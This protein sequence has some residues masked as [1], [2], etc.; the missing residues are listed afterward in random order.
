MTGIEIVQL[1]SPQ[2]T[3][4]TQEEVMKTEK[5]VECDHFVQQ[6]AGMQTSQKM[7][8]S[9]NN[10]DKYK[11]SQSSCL[12]MAELTKAINARLAAVVLAFKGLIAFSH[13]WLR[14]CLEAQFS[15]SNFSSFYNRRIN[16]V[17]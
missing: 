8:N 11:M 17:R 9:H 4:A 1:H 3:V 2:T 15:L 16:F 10:L 13:P 6:P 12:W 5:Q 7:S 14:Y